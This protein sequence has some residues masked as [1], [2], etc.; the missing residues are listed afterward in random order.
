MQNLK[1]TSEELMENG[2]SKE[3][4]YGAGIMKVILAIEQL[5]IYELWNEDLETT[6]RVIRITDLN[7]L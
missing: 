4:M 6:E 1:D 2:N 3:K 5:D 7:K